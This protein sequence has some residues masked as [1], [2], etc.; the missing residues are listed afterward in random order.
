MGGIAKKTKKG[1][2]SVGSTI[3]DMWDEAMHPKSSIKKLAKFVVDPFV[4]NIKGP[5]DSP[6]VPDLE[7]IEQSRRRRRQNKMGRTETIMTSD[8]LG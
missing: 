8:T 6:L 7:Q 1:L 4:P 2:H 3:G 5:P